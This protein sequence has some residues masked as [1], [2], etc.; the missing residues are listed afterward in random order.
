MYL[1][2]NNLHGYAMSQPLLTGKFDWL[3][4]QE[5]E[6][7]KEEN[8]LDDAEGGYTLEVDLEN[9]EELHNTHSDYPL[10]PE[11]MKVIH[12]TL[13]PYCKQL[14]KELNITTTA[15]P[16]FVPNLQNKTNYILHYCNLKL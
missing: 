8:M 1:D 2:A 11:K 16:K 4:E 12:D 14:A 6:D 9:P 13:S 5:I 15:P 7:L 10:A 3:T